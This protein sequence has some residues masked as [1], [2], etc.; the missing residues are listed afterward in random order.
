MMKSIIAAAFMTTA[1]TFVTV[2]TIPV[3][4]K[5]KKVNGTDGSILYEQCR[6]SVNEKKYKRDSITIESWGNQCCSKTEGY[7]IECLA[8]KSYCTKYPYLTRLNKLKAPKDELLAPTKDKPKPRFPPIIGKFQKAPVANAPTKDKP[9]KTLP[10]TTGTMMN[11]V[12]M[13]QYKMAPMKQK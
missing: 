3:S 10:S 6:L 7:C 13:K 5:G 1:F 12:P 2:S 8:G 4:A 11:T 9:N